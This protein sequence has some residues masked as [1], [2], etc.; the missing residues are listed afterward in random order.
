ME[1]ILIAGK[2]RPSDAAG[3][4]HA[5]NPDTGERLEREYPISR[6]AEVEATLR[7]A[8]CY[9]RAVEHRLQMEQGA[10][11]H[12]LPHGA[13]QR[14]RLARQFGHQTWETFYQEYLERTEAV[15]TLCIAAFEGI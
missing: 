13:E 3:S 4:F 10:Q 7:H 8:Y 2:W 11:T 12:T 1:D 5:L 14:L 6:R 15:H 9:L